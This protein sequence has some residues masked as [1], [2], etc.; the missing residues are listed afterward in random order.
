LQEQLKHTHSR[1][2]ISTFLP[3]TA[4]RWSVNSSSELGIRSWQS[5]QFND[6]TSESAAAGVSGLTATSVAS[7]AS[8]GRNAVD[9]ELSRWQSG[10]IFS[11]VISS[12]ER[13][14]AKLKLLAAHEEKTASDSMQVLMTIVSIW[15]ALTSVIPIKW[16]IDIMYNHQKRSG[17]KYLNQTVFLIYLILS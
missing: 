10:K 3:W 14:L 5:G 12:L 6:D 16:H 11:S 13:K 17:C 15:T 1:S 9:E 4:K 8:G 2:K 7:F